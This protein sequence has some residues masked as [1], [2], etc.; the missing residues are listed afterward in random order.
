MDAS[1]G[2]SIRANGAPLPYST[3]DKLGAI[4]VSANA[5]S[6]VRSSDVSPSPL[7]PPAERSIRFHCCRCSSK[8]VSRAR[9]SYAQIRFCWIFIVAAWPGRIGLLVPA[10]RCQVKVMIGSEEHVETPREG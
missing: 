8:S 9:E 5:A 7:R 2:G 4:E 10:L 3:Y 1:L 6:T